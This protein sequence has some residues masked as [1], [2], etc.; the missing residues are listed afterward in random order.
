MTRQQTEESINPC[1]VTAGEALMHVSCIDLRT[2]R[3]SRNSY[4]AQTC[5]AVTQHIMHQRNADQP[6]T[7]AAENALRHICY[8]FGIEGWNIPERHPHGGWLTMG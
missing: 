4:A 8:R 3:H 5:W 2:R 6:S 1:R 7:G